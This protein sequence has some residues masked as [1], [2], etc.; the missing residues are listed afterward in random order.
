MQ[1]RRRRELHWG[2]ERYVSRGYFDG[3]ERNAEIGGL[4]N[5]LIILWL[6]RGVRKTEMRTVEHF[7]NFAREHLR[8]ILHESGEVLYSA[9]S[10]LRPGEVYLIGH[11]PGGDAKNR[12]LPKIGRSLDDLPNKKTNSYLQSWNGRAAGKAPL[13]RRVRW[14]LESLGLDPSKVAAS[15]LIFPRSRDAAGSQFRKYS[16][17]CWPVHEELLGVVQ[18]ALVIA[19]GNGGQS[20]YRFLL[21][22]FG[23]DGE[24]RCNSGHRP[25]LC[26][27][28]VVPGRF[29][30][31]GVP[32]MSRYDISAHSEVV[33]WIKNLSRPRRVS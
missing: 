22:Q 24:E 18:P 28:F 7:A 3:S 6:K 5:A 1:A 19:Y 29:R 25:W 26:R 30:V 15:N 31:V 27:S 16:R 9:A 10:T 4:D 32:H 14:L 12:D 2:C 20:P 11:N 33:E 23:P 8:E 21:N 17:L 13:Q